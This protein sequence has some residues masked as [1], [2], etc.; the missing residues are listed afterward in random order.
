VES[1]PSPWLSPLSCCCDKVTWQKRFKGQ[2]GCFGSGLQ[3]SPAHGVGREQLAFTVEKE[4]SKRVQAR[5]FQFNSSGPCPGNIRIP[6]ACVC[7]HQ[8]TQSRHASTGHGLPR[9][10]CLCWFQ[11]LSRRQWALT[12]RVSLCT[13]QLRGLPSFLHGFIYLF[14]YLFIYSSIYLLILAQFCRVLIGFFILFVIQ[15]V[16]FFNHIHWFHQILH[17]YLNAAVWFIGLLYNIE[18]SR[19]LQRLYI[20]TD[21]V[22]LLIEWRLNL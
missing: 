10:P 14:I 3:V 7:P 15:E 17:F 20:K 2:G 12:V 4:R 9:A 21:Y 5:A 16:F 11:I 13:V 1:Q 6:N 19:N 18:S 8:W 22:I